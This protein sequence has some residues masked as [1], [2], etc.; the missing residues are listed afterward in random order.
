MGV[1]TMRK[2]EI[3]E[4]KAYEGDAEDALMANAASAAAGAK[5]KKRK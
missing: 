5:S 2:K 3:N 1:G 4:G